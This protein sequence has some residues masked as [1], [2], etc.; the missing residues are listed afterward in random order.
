V[1]DFCPAREL[2]ELVNEHTACGEVAK[3]GCLFA[4]NFS[5]TRSTVLRKAER[6][7]RPTT[8][9]SLH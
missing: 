7:I 6:N 1:H 4:W 5:V 3:G 8:T 9:L 2:A